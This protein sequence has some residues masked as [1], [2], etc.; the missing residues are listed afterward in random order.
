MS[1][2][3]RQA[4]RS[5]KFLLP[6]D[7]KEWLPED[8][9]VLFLLDALNQIDLEPFYEG[10]SSDLRGEK[11]YSPKVMI[12]LIIYAYIDGVRSSRKIEKRCQR[13][14]A[15][16][17]A[18]ANEMPDHVTICRFRKENREG[19]KTLFS[20]VLR[21]C[22][23]AGLAEVGTVSL[24]GTKMKANASMQAN[25]TYGYL[26]EKVE[27]IISEAEQI[28]EE[29][30]R[31]YGEG[32]RGDEM[33]EQLTDRESRRKRLKECKERIEQEAREEARKKKEKIEERKKQE[34]KSGKKKR[35]RKPDPPDP[36]PDED[37]RGNP[38]DPESRIMTDRR[39]YMQGYNMQAAVNEN[40]VILA[41]EVSNEENDRKQLEPM[42]KKTEQNV[43]AAGI[44]EKID[45]VVADNGYWNEKSI[46][47]VEKQ[48]GC[49]CVVATEK[50]SKLREKFEE[51]GYPRGRIPEDI[52]FQ[53]LMERRL[54]R[55][56][57]RSKYGK[58]GKTV[59]PVFGQ[60]KE[61]MSCDRMRLRRKEN[62]D[63]EWKLMAIGHNLTKLWRDARRN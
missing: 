14:V 50:G 37:T 4:N 33:P 38:T 53:E 12:P 58:R 32:N 1:S 21:L 47:K 62:V 16:R 25:R 15:Y 7:I 49:E 42:V 2:K 57:G 19:I 60:I 43:D 30:D 41:A 8:H 23:E 26:K 20:E 17:V 40:Q 46:K 6:P 39:G 61:R 29:E 48:T 55:K 35:G 9:L 5:Q 52:T 28:D 56:E 18:A 34:A 13:D 24:D 63:T 10:Y 31:E 27:Q 36:T 59:E 51:E 45:T 54:L 22:A 44:E 11:P 3:F